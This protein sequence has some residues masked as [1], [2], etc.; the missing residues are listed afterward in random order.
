MTVLASINHP[1]LMPTL[2]D[3]PALSKRDG[4]RLEHACAASDR[5]AEQSGC[6]LHRIGICRSRRDQRAGA[7][8]LIL[9]QQRAM[10][11]KPAWQSGALAQRVFLAQRGVAVPGGKIKR[12]LDPH[13][14][15]DRQFTHQV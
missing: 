13:V 1:S 11:E 6:E 4:L 2:T 3:A 14:A 8:D 5:D 12:L 15:G 9:C 10:I 7:G